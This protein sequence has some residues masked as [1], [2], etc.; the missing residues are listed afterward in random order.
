MP[1]GSCLVYT[2]QPWH[3]QLEMIAR[4]LINRDGRAMGFVRTGTYLLGEPGKV[5]KHRRRDIEPL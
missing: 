3:P 2:G 4:V 1:P 5:L